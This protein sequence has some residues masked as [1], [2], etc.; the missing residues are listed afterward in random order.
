MQDVA[1]SMMQHCMVSTRENNEILG[2]VVVL[3]AIDVVDKFIGR[4]LATENSLHDES[5]TRNEVLAASDVDHY[6]P[7]DIDRPSVPL[8][9]AISA[10]PAQRGFGRGL[11]LSAPFAAGRVETS[12]VTGHAGARACFLDAA[13]FR[14]CV[15]Y[16]R[17]RMRSRPA[18][19]TGNLQIAAAATSLRD[20]FQFTAIWAGVLRMLGLSHDPIVTALEGTLP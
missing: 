2:P 15:V 17:L 12:L 18:N 11:P 1:L 3:H 4:Q 13:T 7:F 16:R 14:A 19:L 5:G 8:A 9:N 10:L 6:A 20:A